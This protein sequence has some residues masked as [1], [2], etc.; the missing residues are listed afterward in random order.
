MYF[1]TE[2]AP[3][4]NEELASPSQREQF[5]EELM[6]KYFQ[7][8][9][10]L[11]AMYD[12]LEIVSSKQQETSAELEITHKK[13]KQTEDILWKILPSVVRSDAK[14]E[15]VAS[16]KVVGSAYEEAG[17][18]AQHILTNEQLKHVFEELAKKWRK[19]TINLSS[20]EEITTHDAYLSIIGLGLNVVPLILQELRREPAWWFRALRHVTRSDPVAAEIRGN[21]K[22]MTEAWLNW[23]H[24]NGYL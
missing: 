22:A 4:A 19:E 16:Q 13:A 21:L 18:S 9:E 14:V 20:M 12:R 8:S 11:E 17:I 24:N 15:T 5:L 3:E 23:G 1:D 10:K 2:T 6:D 7:L